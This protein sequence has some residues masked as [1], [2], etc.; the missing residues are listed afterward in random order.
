M[1]EIIVSCK[2]LP[3]SVAL[4]AIDDILE[5]FTERPWHRDVTCWW[6]SSM[7]FL[8][9]NNDYDQDGMA[10]SEEF[11]DVVCACT[12]IQDEIIIA[13]VSVSKFPGSDA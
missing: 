7:L 1:F 8:R 9:A 10:L 12:P 5:E 2:G 3:E 6:K 13:V 4:G 11:S